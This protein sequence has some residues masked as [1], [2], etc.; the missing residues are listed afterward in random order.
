MKLVIGED[1]YPIKPISIGDYEY[2]STQEGSKIGDIELI[3]RF[4]DCPI[5]ELKKQSFH[6][7]KFIA[8]MIRSDFGAEGDTTELPLVYFYKGKPYGLIKPSELSFEEWINLEVFMGQS[9]LNLRLIAT[10]LYKPLKSDKVGDER[11]LVEYELA[12]CESRIP[13]FTD[14]PMPVLTSALFFLATF[15]QKYTESLLGSMENK[16]KKENLMKEAK[17]LQKRKFSK[18]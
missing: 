12:E 14:F 16:M 4:T 8:S 3:Q 5:K 17:N 15:A 9:P 2:F 10:H 6:K 11:E 1:E 18:Q 13:L 7:I